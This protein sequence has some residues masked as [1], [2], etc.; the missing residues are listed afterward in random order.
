MKKKVNTLLKGVA[1]VGVALGGTSAFSDADLVY[2]ANIEDEQQKGIGTGNYEQETASNFGSDSL[3]D[4]MDTDAST[5]ASTEASL[6]ASEEASTAASTE[7][8]T[9]ASL[10]ASEEA[11][12]AASMEASTE[13]ST[14]ASTEASEVELGSETESA[15]VSKIQSARPLMAK[16]NSRASAQDL[17]NVELGEYRGTGDA[18]KDTILEYV[19]MGSI[20]MVKDLRMQDFQVSI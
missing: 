18:Y 20:L 14:I 13:A 19:R 1:G 3:L 12:I 9:E 11:S 10:K 7:A 17:E 16:M 15:F 4:E 8:S 5:E 6:K 2:A